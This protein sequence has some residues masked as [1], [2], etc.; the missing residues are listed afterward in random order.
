L[1]GADK[2]IHF[3]GND[4][5]DNAT[6]IEVDGGGDALGIEMR[7][8]HFTDYEGYDL[9]H[10]GVGDVAYEVKTLSSELREMHPSLKFFHGTVAMGI[11]D[12]VA[13]AVPVLAAQKLLAAMALAAETPIVV[14]DEPTANLDGHAREAFFEQLKERKAAGI[15]VLCSHR[16][17]EVK[18]LVDRVVEFA[19]GHVVR[20]GDAREAS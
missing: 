14:C 1:H 13:H 5:R 9:N 2:G 3:Y 18:R 11:I 19:D 6:A 12:A 4:F 10:D 17:E 7:G 16:I 20:D 15:V 8:N